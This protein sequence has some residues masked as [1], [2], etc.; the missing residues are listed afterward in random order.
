MIALPNRTGS[1][2]LLAASTDGLATAILRVG[3]DAISVR[4]GHWTDEEPRRAPAGDIAAYITHRHD[5]DGED[6]PYVFCYLHAIDVPVGAG[7]SEVTLPELSSVK[8]FA[9][10][11]LESPG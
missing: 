3:S 9:A 4:V 1:L 11:T 10:T 7:V 5:A 6:E 8:I 2:H